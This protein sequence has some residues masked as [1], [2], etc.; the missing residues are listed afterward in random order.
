MCIRYCQ[1]TRFGGTSWIIWPWLFIILWIFLP[2]FIVL[3][4]F[5]LI[6]YSLV[7]IALRY[8]FIH[9]STNM[10]VLFTSPDFP[11]PNIHYSFCWISLFIIHYSTSIPE[12]DVHSWFLPA[13]WSLVW[14]RFKLFSFHCRV[15]R[16]QLMFSYNWT[17][18][19]LTF[20]LLNSSSPP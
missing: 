8:C 15:I 11:N 5:L 18:I 17:T 12:R 2:L 20:A 19:E 6:I 13:L 9:Y 14:K 3:F 1:W 4:K 10:A 7:I 16:E